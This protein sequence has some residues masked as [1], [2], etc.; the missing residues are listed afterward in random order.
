MN[1][2]NLDITK[3][4]NITL[5]Q[6]VKNISSTL[7]ADWSREN[8]SVEENANVGNT[9]QYGFRYKND[10]EDITIWLKESVDKLE[11]TNVVAR[12]TNELPIKRCN[13]ILEVFARDNLVGREKYIIE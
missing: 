11:T 1:I 4:K 2:K 10:E 8:A 3:K 7:G 6:T 5:D 9:R 12:H 13:E